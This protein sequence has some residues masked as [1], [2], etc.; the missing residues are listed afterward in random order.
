MTRDRALKLVIRARAARTGERY[1]AAR[2]QVLRALERPSAAPAL[3]TSAAD[4]QP[5]AAA[6]RS[7][8][9]VSEAKVAENTGYGLAHW[10]DL[11]DR[12]GA[13]EKGHT[14]SARHL[15]E[16]HGV[17]GWYSQ[18][19]TV[20]YERAR[21]VRGVNQRVDGEF[22][23]SVSK[24]VA[25]DSATVAKTLS[26]ARQRRQL[27]G[28]DAELLQALGAALK[29]PSKGIRLRADGL[30]TFRYKWGKTTVQLYLVPRPGGK[31]SL[32]ATSGKLGSAAMVEARRTQW[33]AALNALATLLAA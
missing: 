6:P 5:A 3:S 30:G 29:K 1:T 17:S 14:A 9:P 7:K 24:V 22:E 32:V 31:T 28:V 11:L 18:G 26:S 15:R 21:G 13:I 4:V 33:R 16:S 27:S 8:S 12:F 10:F 23:V 2:R 25:A 20:A 19:I